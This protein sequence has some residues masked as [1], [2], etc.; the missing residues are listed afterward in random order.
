MGIIMNKEQLKKLLANIQAMRDVVGQVNGLCEQV[1]DIHSHTRKL[2]DLGRECMRRENLFIEQ[3]N[4]VYE[5]IN[6]P[7]ATLMAD[8][9]AKCPQPQKANVATVLTTISNMAA[10][11]GETG[12]NAQYLL[13]RAWALRNTYSN[14]AQQ[15]MDNL[16]HNMITKGGCP[17]GI[18]ARL[19]QPYAALLLE[20]LNQT[21][22]H[23]SELL[24]EAEESQY[25]GNGHAATQFTPY[26]AAAAATATLSDE[27]QEEIDL[28]KAFKLSL[29][30]DTASTHTLSEEEAL[31]AMQLEEVLKL[32]LK[33]Q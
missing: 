5:P 3:L 25:F 9:L 23:H 30:T 16:D 7:M 19:V 33:F 6:T 8:I 15:I 29:I 14:G 20:A 12:L 21:Y 10:N 31:E 18:A 26:Y 28:A 32:S 17:A 24:I 4:E 11:E 2:G 13:Q 1:V 22:S 27:E